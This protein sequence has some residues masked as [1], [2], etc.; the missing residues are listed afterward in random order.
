MLGIFIDYAIILVLLMAFLDINRS[1]I[2][3]GFLYTEDSHL[4]RQLVSN[5]LLINEKRKR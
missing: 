5:K 1:Q 2:I 4:K 3:K